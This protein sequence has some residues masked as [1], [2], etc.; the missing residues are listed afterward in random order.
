MKDQ[1]AT[2][3]TRGP[4]SVY[5]ATRTNLILLGVGVFVVLVLGAFP[6]F[7]G[8]NWALRLIDFFLYLTLAQMFNLLLGYGGIISVGLQGFIGIGAYALWMFSDVL[9]I[10]PFVS[11]VLAGVGGVMIALP[12]A[13]VVF[14]LKGAYLAIGTWIIAEALKLVVSNIKATGG[15]SGKTI[16]AVND[17]SLLSV[18]TR[19]YATYYMALGIAIVAMAG[20]YLLLRSR[21]GLSMQAM[22]DNQA[23]SRSLGVN[24]WRTRMYAFVISGG[25]CAMIGALVAIHL[26]RVQPSAAFSFNWMA[27]ILIIALV[28]G[29]GTLEGPIIGTLLF[30]LLRETTSQYGQWYFILLGVLAIVVVIWSPPGIYGAIARRTGFYVFPLRRRVKVSEG[31]GSG[32]ILETIGEGGERGSI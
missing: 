23:A 25:G 27:F 16:Q 7:A 17:T 11:V 4:S 12:A 10:N 3:T 6:M 20:M 5:V 24:V 31:E 28:G 32:P 30:L 21:L 15:N 1:V 14:R 22:R 2:P 13:A 9:H 29:L 26:L 8:T 19:I 18:Q